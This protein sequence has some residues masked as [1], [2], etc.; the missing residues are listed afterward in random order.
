MKNDE[1]NFFQRKF[2]KILM[3]INAIFLAVNGFAFSFFP[4]EIS[5]LLN[6]EDNI[7]FILT[8]QNLGALYLGFSYVN[9]MS[10]N[11]LIG[12]IYNKPLLIGNIL[13]FLTASMA[14]LKLVFKFENNFQL[15]L[16]FTLIYCLFTLLFGYV[17][18]TNPFSKKHQR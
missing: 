6:N 18:F 12:G 5:V 4:V 1:K 13:H 11:S 2:T 8:L 3:I 16:S 9:W 15:I 7:F 17:F 10:K 14:M